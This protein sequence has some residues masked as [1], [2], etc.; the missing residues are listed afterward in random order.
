MTTMLEQ[1][2]VDAAALKE[3]AV[4]NAETVILEKYAEEIKE[5]VD[6]VL[7]QDDEEGLS[8]DIGDED[9]GTG[10][11]DPV[12]QDLPMAATDGDKVCPCPEEDEEVEINFDELA[13]AMDDEEEDMNAMGE[14]PLGEQDET[15]TVEVPAHLASELHMFHY[16]MGDPIYKVGSLAHAGKP[17]PVDLVEDAIGNLESFLGKVDE[18]DRETLDTLIGELSSILTDA[19]EPYGETE[20]GD[21]D[22]EGLTEEVIDGIIESLEVDYKNVPNGWDVGATDAQKHEAAEAALAATQDDRIKEETDDLK[23]AFEEIAVL[24]ENLNK[25]REQ[26]KKLIE[27]N[28]SLTASYNSIKSTAK[29]A[30]EKLNEMNIKNAKLFYQNRILKSDSLNEQQKKRLVEAVSKVDSVEKAKLAF[31]T[32]QESLN[33]QKNRS[34]KDE[35]INEVV[36][37][38]RGSVLNLGNQQRKA[39]DPWKLRNQVLAGIKK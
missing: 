25:S 35:T 16:G 1:A 8:L 3:A 5:V 21:D 23:K 9:E 24:K 14:Q 37:R 27:Q 33:E 39:E 26:N 19:D 11:V 6:S 15:Q 36:G 10:E 28:K 22:L 12:A 20:F 2:V 29:K 18:E 7:E 17:V 31:E 34:N 38:S 4:R 32:L 13:Q 30:G